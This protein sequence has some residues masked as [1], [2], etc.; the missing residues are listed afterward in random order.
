MQT[1]PLWLI[2]CVNLVICSHLKKRPKI[3]EEKIPLILSCIP[4]ETNLLKVL[5]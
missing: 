4:E 2:A 5:L 3:M 1:E